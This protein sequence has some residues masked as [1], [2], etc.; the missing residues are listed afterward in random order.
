MRFFNMGVKSRRRRAPRGGG[1]VHGNVN[2][3]DVN[4]IA[5]VCSSLFW[6]TALTVVTATAPSSA[7]TKRSCEVRILQN[8]SGKDRLTS[9]NESRCCYSGAEHSQH[10]ARDNQGSSRAFATCVM[11]APSSGFWKR[12]LVTRNKMQA[13]S[14]HTH[15]HKHTQSAHATCH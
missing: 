13:D 2:R 1:R 5:T 9:R 14:D 7:T 11:Y 12:R 10:H 15:V 6:P 3:Y 8:A 4:A